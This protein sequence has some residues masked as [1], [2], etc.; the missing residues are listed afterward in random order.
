MLFSSSANPIDDVEPLAPFVDH[1][2]NE[3]G[4]VLQIGIHHCDDVTICMRKPG[5]DCGLVAEIA[6]EAHK[7]DPLVLH[8]EVF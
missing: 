1:L 7:L 8:L 2:Y 6:R 5:Q 3:L 4:W